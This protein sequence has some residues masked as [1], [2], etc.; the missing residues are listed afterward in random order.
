M[1]CA[2]MLKCVC[3]RMHACA[4]AQESRRRIVFSGVGITDGC[5]PP[6]VDVGN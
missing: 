3:A 6:H 4:D 1:P 2:S 5:E